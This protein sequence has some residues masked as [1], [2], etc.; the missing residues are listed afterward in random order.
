MTGPLSLRT[1]IMFGAMATMALP[2]PALAALTAQD[3]W[4]AFSKQLTLYG[5]MAAD[6]TQ[7]GDTLS[8]SEIVLSS[9]IEEIRSETALSG[10]IAFQENGDGTVSI[11]F[12]EQM[13]ASMTVSGPDVPSSR[14]TYSFGHDGMVVTASGEPGNI[15]HEFSAPKMTYVL[16]DM[17]FNGAAMDG[18]V[19][20]ELTNTAGSWLSAGDALT[21]IT[22]DYTIEAMS[23]MAAF[24]EPANKGAAQFNVQLQDIVAKSKNTI[25]EGVQTLTPQAIFTNGFGVTAQ[26]DYGNLAY[27]AD[28][29]TNGRNTKAAGTIEKGQLQVAMDG[30]QVIYAT[31]AEQMDVS[32]TIA[33]LPLP[34]V[35]VHLDRS[36]FELQMPLAQTDMARDFGLG[37]AMEGFTISDFIWSLFDPAQQLPRD[38]ANIVVDLKGTGN[39]LVDI[40]DPEALDAAAEAPGTI[41]TLSLE[42]LEITIAGASL[43]GDGAFT[44]DNDDLATFGGV[45]RPEGA[46]NLALSG[47]ITLLDKLTA[48]NIVPQQQAAGIKLMT[49]LFTTPGPGED[50]LTSRIEIDR[51]G[52]VLANGQQIR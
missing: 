21:E 43:T 45:P 36:R 27:T 46:I 20:L 25:P 29:M 23:V 10:V 40:F 14:M 49:G 11:A 47:G 18:A 6:V 39:W 22:A 15:A 37:V 50:A 5:G 41:E 44:F 51:D 17:S 26:L 3:V 19:E 4:D 12:P 48:M 33:G 2:A 35:E 34:P 1:S 38:P 16:N 30:D 28:L 7:S 13:T 52:R 8:V 42:A 24:A 32:S 31:S 9:E